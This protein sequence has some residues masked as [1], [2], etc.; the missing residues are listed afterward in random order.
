MLWVIIGCVAL[1]LF[2]ALTIYA[3]IVVGGEADKQQEAWAE[4][5]F[6]SDNGRS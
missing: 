3:C 1:F 2:F 6:D 5:L 4:K